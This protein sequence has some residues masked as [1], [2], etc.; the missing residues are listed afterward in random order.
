MKPLEE[1][2]VS[3]F[4]YRYDEDAPEERSPSP[5]LTVTTTDE[6]SPPSTPGRVSS[7]FTTIMKQARPAD[8]FGFGQ[9]CFKWVMEMLSWSI[10]GPIYL[11]PLI[12]LLLLLA[13]PTPVANV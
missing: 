1:G 12:P 11:A 6:A 9:M 10:S 4:E 2:V 3:P 8:L 7:P 5:S 13:L